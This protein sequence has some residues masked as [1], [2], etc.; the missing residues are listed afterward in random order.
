[1]EKIIN[2]VTGATGRLGP[3]LCAELKKRG[4]YVR[5]LAREE[6]KRTE[7]LE[8]SID[9]LVIGD[10]TKAETLDKAFEGLS[11][12]YHLA[13]VVSIATKIS[14]ALYTVNVEGT[15]NVVE[16]CIKH[17]VKRLLETGTCHT[18]PFHDHTSI[19]REPDHFDPNDFHAG[20]EKTKAEGSQL[21]LEAVQTRGLDAVIALP[22]AILG[23]YELKRSNFG[24]LVVNVA[25]G[26]MPVSVVG[27]GYD[28]VDVRDVAW[29]MV[30]MMDKGVKGECY[31]LSGYQAGMDELIRWAA[32]G[33]SKYF[34]RKVKAPKITLPIKFV[35]HFA[36]LAEWF[37]VDILH[38]EPT[39]T[40]F[41]INSVQY[42]Y[43]FTFEKMA[44][45]CGY[46]PRP[47]KEAVFDQVAYYYDVYKP[48]LADSAKL[49]K[50]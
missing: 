30:E 14:P 48:K 31:L 5:A 9:E 1:M 41:A 10:I 23:P 11:Y 35:G 38:Q 25:E 6:D 24:Q 20:Y 29:G 33:A 16:A 13:G 26:K 8:G 22:T 12:C 37:F 47:V 32:E 46:N 18:V 7:L 21:V 2:L 34:G 50:H 36:R 39:F 15:R 28:W 19:M 45:L 44:A 42:N 27:G 40:P 4:R 43:N 49:G 3:A 17:K